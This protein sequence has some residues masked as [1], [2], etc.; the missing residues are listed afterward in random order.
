M[1]YIAVVL[2]VTNFQGHPV[3]FA[4]ENYLMLL[5]RR[6]QLY[7]SQADRQF[8]APLISSNTQADPEIK[9]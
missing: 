9:V 7:P 2:E 1:I 5:H 6:E 3:A 8:I 4:L